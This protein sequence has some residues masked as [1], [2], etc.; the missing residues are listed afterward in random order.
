MHRFEKRSH[1]HAGYPG[2]NYFMEQ[3]MGRSRMQE[4]RFVGSAAKS[5]ILCRQNELD[6]VLPIYISRKRRGGYT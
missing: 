4:I 6:V 3:Q 5:G 2:S 1:L